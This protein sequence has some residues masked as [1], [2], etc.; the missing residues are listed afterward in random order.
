MFVTSIPDIPLLLRFNDEEDKVGIP[1]FVPKFEKGME[2]QSQRSQLSDIAIF[3]TI[4]ATCPI[5]SD[6]SDIVRYFASKLSE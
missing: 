5:L 6:M 4:L 2:S 3:S 1:S